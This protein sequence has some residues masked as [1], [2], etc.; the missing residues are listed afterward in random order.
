M[1]LVPT[2]EDQAFSAGYGQASEAGVRVI[3]H[4]A[5]RLRQ[6]ETERDALRAALREIMFNA[7]SG[8]WTLPS[9]FAGAARTA[10]NGERTTPGES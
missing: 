10:L 6:V 9:S 7:E 8:K 5:G 3:D 1:S 4:L 2:R